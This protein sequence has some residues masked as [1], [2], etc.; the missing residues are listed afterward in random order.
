M[1]ISLVD[2]G[3]HVRRGDAPRRAGDYDKATHGDCDLEDV[4]I[5]AMEALKFDAIDINRA[6]KRRT[7]RNCS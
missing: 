2:A 4:E 1:T 6:Y 7:Y 3:V 5:K